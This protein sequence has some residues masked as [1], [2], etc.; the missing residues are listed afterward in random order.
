VYLRGRMRHY[1]WLIRPSVLV[2]LVR[3]RSARLAASSARGRR[4]S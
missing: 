4:S 3:R 2:S 1:R